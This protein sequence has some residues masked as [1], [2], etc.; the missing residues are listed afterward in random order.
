MLHHLIWLFKGVRVFTLVGKS[1]TG[2]SFRAQL[3]AEKY[4]IGLIIDDGLLIKDQKILAGQSAKKEKG[5]LA[6]IRTALFTDQ[7]HL[8]NVQHAL[9]KENFKRVLIIGTSEKLV[10]KIASKLRLPQPSKIVQ[11]EEIAT[12]EEIRAAT[13]SRN[14]HGRHIIP[15]PAVEVKRNY[16]HIFFDSVKIFFRH[17]F[18]PFKKGNIFEKT[19][20][21]PEYSK[22]GKV[23]IS[24]AAL[25]QMVLHCIQE[26]D[27]SLKAEK[28]VVSGDATE[29]SLEIILDVPYGN[30]IAGTLYQL[31]KYII[32]SIEQFTGL[33]LK[34][35]D[36]TI[37][38]V[39][40]KHG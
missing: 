33:I 26:F 37:G 24:E 16:P 30:Q 36:L 40:R 27:E 19:I 21:R 8:E 39:T 2:K 11:I 31:Q 22:R 9:S 3:I 12:K 20:V 38:K 17:R 7:A 1:G 18:R 25:S 28:I 10:R 4:G 15:V 32:E 6:A 34:E 29:Y 23:T 14:S 13:W 35:V 5:I